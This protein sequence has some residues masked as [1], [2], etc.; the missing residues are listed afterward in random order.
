MTNEAKVGIFV[1]IILILFILLSMQIGELTLGR[2]ETYPITMVFSSVDG[3]KESSPLELAGVEVGKV[4]GISLNKDFSALVRAAIH[5]DI[6]LPIDST[7]SIATKGVLGDKI[8]ILTPGVSSNIIEP[9]G[10]L[11]RTRIPPSLDLL[12]TQLGELAANLT[13][14]SGVF[15]E[16]FGDE[17]LL[18][19]ILNNVTQ[20]SESAAS[21]L[22][23]NREGIAE[24]VISLGEI[25]DNFATVSQNLS[26]TSD[27]IDQITNT[28]SAGEGTL[29]KLVHD[30]TLYL[31]L[32]DFLDSAQ[33]FT[34][35]LNDDSTVSMLMTDP[36]LYENLLA[37]SENIR[38][39]SEEIASGRGTLGH[40][41]VDDDL[42]QEIKETIRSVNLAARGLEEQTPI[43]IMGTILGL[44]W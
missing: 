32:V 12:L 13:E 10:N 28:I 31:S 19:G 29:G 11:A 14:L 15:N 30:D 27:H 24:I 9:G 17:E 40:I 38:F 20:F 25:T 21:I 22:S 5:E 16:V 6:R 44:I 2:K 43:T 39:I 1:V 7:A 42:Y 41:L 34:S 4:V 18:R 37:V 36:S 23:E 33:A 8:I 35:R 3:L 26:T